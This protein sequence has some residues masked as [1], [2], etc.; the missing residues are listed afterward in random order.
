MILVNEPLILPTPL[1]GIPVTAAALS[2]VQVYVV[3]AVALVNAIVVIAAPEQAFWLDGVAT[4]TG[5]GLTVI[6]NILGV[7]TQLEKM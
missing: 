1:P 5:V 6:V 7:P 4:A 2:L 3:P